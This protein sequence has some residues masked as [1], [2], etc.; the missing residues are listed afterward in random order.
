[1]RPLYWSSLSFIASPSLVSQPYIF[2]HFLCS[3]SLLLG[4]QVT[5]VTQLFLNQWPESQ[6]HT[7]TLTHTVPV[8]WCQE[9][10]ET[11][12]GLTS[13]YQQQLTSPQA[14]HKQLIPLHLPLLLSLY[15]FLITVKISNIDLLLSP[16]CRLSF[17][18]MWNI[19]P[20]SHYLGKEDLAHPSVPN[21]LA[22]LFSRYCETFSA[23]YLG[24]IRRDLYGV[25]RAGK[26]TTKLLICILV[27]K[28]MIM[29]FIIHELT[30]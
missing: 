14:A 21:I 20:V 29:S 30:Q 17:V 25:G 3:S 7:H 12:D 10:D 23:V 2:F 15:N 11:N 24:T 19:S 4:F 22:L 18:L 16:E 6:S 5:M 1:M 9:P 28:T 26:P 13:V 27:N 8:W